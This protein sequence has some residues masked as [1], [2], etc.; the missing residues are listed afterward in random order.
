ML[1]NYFFFRAGI[2]F[3]PKTG[4]ALVP[5]FVKERLTAQSSQGQEVSYV[6]IY[7]HFPSMEQRLEIIIDQFIR[8]NWNESKLVPKKGGKDTHYKVDLKEGKLYVAERKKKYT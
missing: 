1:F 6:D 4:M 3:S 7:R 2:G 8:N 5:N